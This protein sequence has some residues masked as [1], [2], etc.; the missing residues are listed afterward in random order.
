MA[1]ATRPAPEP[2]PQPLPPHRTDSMVDGAAFLSASPSANG[3]AE[4]A[5][6]NVAR[7]A[8][9]HAVA[10]RL[11]MDFDIWFSPVSVSRIAR[12]RGYCGRLIFVFVQ[13]AMGRPV[14]RLMPRGAVLAA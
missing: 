10:A 4:A 2:Q 9:T 8:A 13:F 11:R 12:H 3:M 7:P 14:S 5:L 1:P 6:A